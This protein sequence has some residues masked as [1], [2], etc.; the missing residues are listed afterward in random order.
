MDTVGWAIVRAMIA[1]EEV[2]DAFRTMTATVHDRMCTQCK[3]AAQLLCSRCGVARF[4]SDACQRKAW[5]EHR[6]RCKEAAAVLAAPPLPPEM[7]FAFIEPQRAAAVPIPAGIAIFGV[8]AVVAGLVVGKI[9]GAII[10]VASV[11]GDGSDPAAAVSTFCNEVDSGL[12]I[13]NVTRSIFTW[14]TGTLRDLGCDWRATADAGHEVVV[15]ISMI[16]VARMWRRRGIGRALVSGLLSHA[17]VMHHTIAALLEGGEE[18]DTAS[19]V[20]ATLFFSA[21]GFRPSPRGALPDLLMLRPSDARHS[22]RLLAAETDASRVTSRLLQDAAVRVAEATER[23][24]AMRR[25]LKG[26]ALRRHVAERAL[27]AR[28]YLLGPLAVA[29]HE[30]DLESLHRR[31]PR[32]VA[33]AKAKGLP[34]IHL[35]NARL[36]YAGMVNSE[37]DAMNWHM[38]VYDVFGPLTAD[39]ASALDLPPHPRNRAVGGGVA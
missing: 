25:G 13:A 30:A 39:E 29:A 10:D 18:E 6:S 2:V 26:P 16:R 12:D 20:N 7:E 21:C 24:K 1:P 8:S 19:P 28:L 15:I 36:S 4:C 38:V 14:G 5:P 11:L 17:R 3:G 9:T 32:A 22:A 23:A 33:A 27:A 34:E 35:L 31:C 37:D